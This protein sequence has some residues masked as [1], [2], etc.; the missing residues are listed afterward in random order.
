MLAD[1]MLH[2]GDERRASDMA[3]AWDARPLRTLAGM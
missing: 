2:L 3:R 1:P